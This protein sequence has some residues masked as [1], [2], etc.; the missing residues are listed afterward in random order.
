MTHQRHPV[1]VTRRIGQ[2]ALLRPGATAA[3]VAHHAD[4]W[5][6]VLDALR[7]AG[8]RNYS[9]FRRRRRLFAYFEYDGHDL[10]AALASVA[11]DP[12]MQRWTAIMGILLEPQ[13]PG[14]GG[15]PWQALPAIFHMR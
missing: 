6:E 4:V 8:I 13:E 9:I 5:P 7:Q 15:S 2:T 1:R 3:Y 12:A 10:D 14:E 11:L